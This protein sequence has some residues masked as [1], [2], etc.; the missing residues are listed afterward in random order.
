MNPHCLDIP[1]HAGGGLVP[2]LIAMVVF[3]ALGLAFPLR[4]SVGLDRDVSQ[5]RRRLADLETLHPLYV[6]LQ[7][8][9]P[10]GQWQTLPRPPKQRLTQSE[11]TE[12]PMVLSRMAR[13]ARLELIT[14]RPQVAAGADGNRQ[15]QVD[16]QAAGDY[17]HMRDFLMAVIGMPS[18]DHI[19]RLDLQRKNM[20]ETLTLSFSLALR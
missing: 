11:V 5:A 12:V 2:V 15:L 17:A 20:Q 7:S 4:R 14:V 6:E 9:R 19:S 18:M 16:L 3:G 13:D 8:F 10:D 1:R